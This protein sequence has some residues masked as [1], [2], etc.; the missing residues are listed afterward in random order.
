[1]TDEK[2][3]QHYVP[4]SY[5]RGFAIDGEKSLIWGYS[6]E[7]GKCTGKRS[8][9]SICSEE[10]YY[11]QP[12][13]DGT[14]T[15]VLEDAFQKPEKAAIEIIKKLKPA[16]SFSNY[17]KGTLAFYI[18]I[19]LTRGP[20]FRDGIHTSLK[21]LVETSVQVLYKEGILKEPPEEIKKH[22]KDNDL[23][24]VMKAEI[25]PHV[26]LQYMINGAIQIGNS[27]CNK[28]WDFFFSKGDYYITSD[29]PVIF[30]PPPGSNDDVGP[31][32]PQSMIICPLNKN[33]LLSARPY[34]S[35]DNS[36]YE[37]RE[38]EKCFVDLVNKLQCF[39]SQKYV[40]SPLRSEELLQN[41]KSAS[42]YSQKSRAYR[43]GDAVFSKW[44][45][46]KD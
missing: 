22:I 43:F 21:H 33:I 41:V 34:H 45:V 8:V 39:S 44:G 17:D 30:G 14:T 11:Q 3:N 1:M 46:D 19:M 20:S 31:G 5:L 6:K 32:N 42:G 40:Y 26:S 36:N 29:T 16:Y 38:A 35:S 7:H 12:M 2:K 18:A 13:P 27:L 10:Y 25:F 9:D 23:T 4:A 24:S 15:Q 37:F 28:K